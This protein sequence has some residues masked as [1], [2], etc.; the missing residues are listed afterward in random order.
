MLQNQTTQR[1]EQAVIYTRVACDGPGS[2]ENI[3]RQREA[4]RALAE[5]LNIIVTHEFADHGTSGNTLDRPAL[6][7]L[8]DYVASHPVQYL[9]CTS[10]H[11]LSRDDSRSEALLLQLDTLGVQV[12]LTEPGAAVDVAVTLTTADAGEGY[13]D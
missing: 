8:L 12:V 4:C 5:Q 3:E 9:I 13:R 6:R 10:G 11:I 1:P 7:A 2:A